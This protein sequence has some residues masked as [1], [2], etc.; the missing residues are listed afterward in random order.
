M[1]TNLIKY[2]TNKYEVMTITVKFNKTFAYNNNN[3]LVESVFHYYFV[4]P[5]SHKPKV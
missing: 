5:R 4:D 1:P 3:N 2:P